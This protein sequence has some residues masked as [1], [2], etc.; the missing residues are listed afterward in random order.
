MLTY[1]FRKRTTA[2]AGASADC[3]SACRAKSLRWK[4][5][6]QD[7]AYRCAKPAKCF[8]VEQAMAAAMARTPIEEPSGTWCV[9]IGGGTTDIAVIFDE[10][11]SCTRVPCAWP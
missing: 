4:A 3:G 10:P 6:V 2:R 5:R 11:A 1:L 8:L 9:D 7:P